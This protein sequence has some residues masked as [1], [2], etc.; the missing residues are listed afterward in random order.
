MEESGSNTD[1]KKFVPVMIT[2]FNQSCNIDWDGLSDLIDFYLAAGVKGLFANCLSSEMYSISEEERFKLIRHIVNRTNAVIP[3]VAAGS[4]GNTI[5]E[6]AESVRKIYD[7]GA[8]AVILITSHFAKFEESDEQLLS[9]FGELFALTSKIP[10]GLYECPAPYKR[11]LSPAVFQSLVRSNRLIYHK[12]TSLSIEQVRHKIE[13]LKDEKNN[14]LEFYDAHTPNA[15]LSLQSGAKGLSAIAGNFYP[16]IMTWICNHATHPDHIEIVRWL[17]SEI[18]NSDP[19]I[20]DAYP[21]SSKYFLRK[22]GLHL[23]EI[24]RVHPI[25][26]TVIQKKILDETYLKFLGWCERLEISPV[27]L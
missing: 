24:S 1:I 4:F 13:I 23:Q 26:L 27:K 19:L 15:L 9:N 25:A 2:P 10:L 22:R 12:D 21:L 18:T 16:E 8:D 20:H 17:Q 14:R 5:Q 3:V 7:T 11:I 6:K